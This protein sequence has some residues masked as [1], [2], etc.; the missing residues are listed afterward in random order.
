MKFYTWNF[1]EYCPALHFLLSSEKKK[2]AG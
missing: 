2:H 1:H